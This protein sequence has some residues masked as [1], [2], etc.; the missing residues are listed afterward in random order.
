MPVMDGYEATTL[1]REHEYSLPIIA[2]T[3]HTMADERRFVTGRP[4]KLL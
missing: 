1:L 4:E 2:L 3:A